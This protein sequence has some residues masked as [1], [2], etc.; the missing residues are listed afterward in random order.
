MRIIGINSLP[1]SLPPSLSS[2]SPILSLLLFSFFCSLFQIKKEGRG[3][4]RNEKKKVRGIRG[5]KW[6]F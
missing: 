1:P 2:L 4:K 5:K 6:Y 3:R